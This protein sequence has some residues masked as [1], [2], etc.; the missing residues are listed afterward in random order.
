MTPSPNLH[1]LPTFPVTSSLNLFTYCLHSQLLAA[2][3]SLPAA[4]IHSNMEPQ[5]L[6]LLP[7]LSVTP[8]LNLFTYCL[9]SQ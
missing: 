2:S 6:Y 9:H 5:P 4:Y 8:I 3:T 1:L 7:T